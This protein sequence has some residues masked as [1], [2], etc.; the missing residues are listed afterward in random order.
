MKAG[1]FPLRLRRAAPSARL[2]RKPDRADRAFQ[3]VIGGKVGVPLSDWNLCFVM[4]MPT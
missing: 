4:W 1:D 3:L 2:L